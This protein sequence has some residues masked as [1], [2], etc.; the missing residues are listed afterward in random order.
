MSLQIPKFLGNKVPVFL[1]FCSYAYMHASKLC[2]SLLWNKVHFTVLNNIPNELVQ[3]Y[4]DPFSA[5]NFWF[6][7][8][9]QVNSH[10]IVCTI[11]FN[12]LSERS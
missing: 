3:R 10:M 2:W 6:I 1:T 12:N 5:D 11:S 7:N 4:V 9:G 8:L